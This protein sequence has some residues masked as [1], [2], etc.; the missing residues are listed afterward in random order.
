MCSGDFG[1]AYG[2]V[3][4]VREWELRFGWGRDEELELGMEMELC[5]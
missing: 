2:G 4:V 3:V 5:I 1:P